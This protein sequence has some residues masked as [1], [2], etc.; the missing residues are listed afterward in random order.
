MVTAGTLAHAPGT[1]HIITLAMTSICINK[2]WCL[3]VR[4]SAT[5]LL[6]IKNASIR[7]LIDLGDS[8]LFY[9]D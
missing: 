4:L 7:L 1:K 9:T 2:T 6:L 3:S 5:L 8:I